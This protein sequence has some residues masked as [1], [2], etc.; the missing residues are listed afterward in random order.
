MLVKTNN[1][2]FFIRKN[3]IDFKLANSAYEISVLKRFKALLPLYQV[4]IDV[5]ANIGTYSLI[6]A[7]YGVKSIAFEPIPSNFCSLKKNIKLNNFDNLIQPLMF[8]LSE[9]KE[10]V[11]F[12]F[13]PLK[14]GASSIHPHKRM[15]DIINVQLEEFD[16]L[17]LNEIEMAEN[18]LIKIDIEGMEL[19]AL[20][21]MR[22]MLNQKKNICLIIETKHSGA[23]NI[24][25]LIKE[26]GNYEFENIDEFNMLAIKTI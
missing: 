22:K 16:Q 17:G 4:F 23:K 24:K 26:Y 9:K 11:D 13:D 7:R 14:P 25:K 10:Q 21:G 18:I 8:G 5:G 2:I 15:G 20:K 19:N 1:G 12:N 3:T 6:A